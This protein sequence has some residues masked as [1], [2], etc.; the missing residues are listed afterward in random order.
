MKT[1]SNLRKWVTSCFVIL[2]SPFAIPAF[3]QSMTAITYQ[4]RLNNGTNPATGMYDFKFVSCTNA[5][6]GNDGAT[7]TNR[8][9]GV[10]NGLFTTLIDFG[11]SPDSFSPRWLEI[12][13]RTN[14]AGAFAT[15]APRQL[16]TPAPYAAY[17]LNASNLVGPISVAQ[18]VGSP[19]VATNFSGPLSGE[20]TGT[21][22]ATVVA[23]V[24]GATAASVASGANA[25]NAASSENTTSTIVRRDYAGNFSAGTITLAGNLM[26]PANGVISQEGISLIQA[27]AAGNFFAGPGAGNFT[28]TG[29]Y[30][31][32]VGFSALAYNTSGNYNTADGYLAL[33]YNT[34]GSYN[35][36]NGSLALVDNLS[37]SEN[38]AIGY[39]SLAGNTNGYRNTAIGSQSLYSNTSGAENTA[40][41]FWALY[42][43]ESGRDNTADGNQA[44]Y[45]NTSGNNNTAV[46]NQALYANA[47]GNNN[48]ATGGGALSGN[49]SGNDNTAQG[50]AAL[51]NN[52]N[53]TANVAIG[54][55]ALAFNR[56]GNENTAVGLQALGRSATGRGNIGVGGY[57]GYNLNS[58]NDNIYLGNRGSFNETGIVRIGTLGIQTNVFI[59]GIFG[60]TSVGGAS[61]YATSSGQLATLTSSARFKQ[62]IQNMGEA[63]QTLLALRPVTFKYK[64]EIDTQARP[65][66]GLIAEEVD[67]VNPDLVIHD[68]HGKPYTV[69]YEAVNAMLLNEFLKQHRRNES[70][71]AEIAEL[72]ARLSRMETI[73]QRLATEQK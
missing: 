14:G 29:T 32:G 28:M 25:A 3:A 73:L 70:Q 59:A 2:L 27:S 10:T 24:G 62:D 49:I 67:K 56:S 44:L 9:V 72:K 54:S 11:A 20:V 68:D 55:A 36:A 21:Q 66:F 46:G 4:G 39:R 42:G 26:L 5:T 57:A 33:G 47:T 52:T 37:G 71:G 53:G 31:N 22:S 40:S 17:A 69:R 30:V 38:T 8:A 45:S 35:T 7:T 65:Q 64:T 34:E 16:L 48:A 15:L 60:T 1:H 13:V 19:S 43:N 63:S 12:G 6:L 50:G 18:L 41:G 61:V 58:G 51:A 23:E